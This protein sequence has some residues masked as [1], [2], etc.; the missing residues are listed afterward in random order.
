M[1][2]LLWLWAFLAS[3]TQLSAQTTDFVSDHVH[4]IALLGNAKDSLYEKI[5]G[6][7]DTYIRKHP[8]EAAVAIERCKFIQNAYYDNYEDYNPKDEEAEACARELLVQFPENPDVL[9]FSTEFLYGDTLLNYLTGL[10]AKVDN[11]PDDWKDHSWQVYQKFAEHYRYNANYKDNDK[12]VIH[13]GELAQQKNDTLDLSL[14][15]AQAHKNLSHRQEAIDLLVNSLDSTKDVWD[16]NQRGRLLLELGAPDEALKVFKLA[17]RDSSDYED[18]GSLAQALIDNGLPEE[19]RVY[20]VKSYE[21]NT[22]NMN[23]LHALLEY[24][25]KYAPGDT[26]AHT[27]E[28]FVESNFMNDPLGMYRLKLFI[29]QP[30]AGWSV[31]DVLRL[32]FLA[33]LFA[34]V[35]VLPYLWVLPIHYWGQWRRAQGKIFQE[36]AFSWGLRH[37]WTIC[38]LWLAMDVATTLIFDYNGI[39][40]IVNDKIGA[41]EIDVIGKQAANMM[42]FFCIGCFV[43]TLGLLKRRDFIQFAQSWKHSSKHI[44]MGLGLALALR[45]GLG[46]Y[47]KIIH[48]FDIDILM[49]ESGI[50]SIADSIHAVNQFYS[51]V[52]GFL[53]VVIIVPFYEEILFRGVFLSACSRNMKFV[54]ANMLQSLMFALAHQDFIYMPFYFAFGMVAGHYQRKT[55]ALTVGISLHVFNN[56]LSFVTILV[57]K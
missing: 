22:W 3:I 43:F 24:D 36:P 25:L 44:F 42:I 17:E 23:A 51:P 33:L 56:L 5:L 7:Y 21:K 50:L 34:I 29:K 20:L 53:L 35:L 18:H 19:A 41:E 11:H 12:E 38:S 37:Y 39:I 40:S 16:L 15:L 45:F 49:E 46:L 48:A 9:L 6:Q 4:H 55:Q 54:F 27:Y 26:A 47:L 10:E 52:L 8:G 2:H 31:Q 57:L 13:Y 1:K 30:L 28:R 14:M 32:V